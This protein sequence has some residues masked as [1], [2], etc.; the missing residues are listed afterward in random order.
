MSFTTATLIFFGVIQVEGEPLPLISASR[1][2]TSL[3]A[4]LALEMFGLAMR[5]HLHTDT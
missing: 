2:P 5:Q 1:P 4:R 3:I